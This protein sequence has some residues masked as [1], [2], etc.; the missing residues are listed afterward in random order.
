MKGVNQGVSIPVLNLNIDAE[1]NTSKFD[2]KNGEACSLCVR[3][4]HVH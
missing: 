2:Y 4:S 3:I 1:E